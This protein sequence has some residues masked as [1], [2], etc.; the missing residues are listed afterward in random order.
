MSKEV[1]AFEEIISTCTFSSYESVATEICMIHVKDDID[2]LIILA[3]ALKTILRI[4]RDT[5]I[6][7]SVV[8]QVTSAVVPHCNQLL[9]VSSTC[10]AKSCSLLW[11]LSVTPLLNN[12]VSPISAWILAS[13][14][15]SS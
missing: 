4:L 15:I 10:V 9:L 7:L 13:S 11:N 6:S 12:A 8:D 5:R 14:S 3:Q 1:E 2:N